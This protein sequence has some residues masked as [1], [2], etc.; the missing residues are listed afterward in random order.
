MTL[1]DIDSQHSLSSFQI[2]YYTK[3][4]KTI[5]TLITRGYRL[6][7]QCYVTRHEKKRRKFVPCI[8]PGTS[9]NII[10]TCSIAPPKTGKRR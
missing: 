5:F 4:V 7:N 3:R 8:N 1:T 6:G 2:L 10:Y 9:R